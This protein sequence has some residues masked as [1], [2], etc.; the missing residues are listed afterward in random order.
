MHPSR[1]I[2]AALA[3]SILLAATTLGAAAQSPAP[4]PMAAAHVTGRYIFDGDQTVVATMTTDD[5]VTRYRGG[6]TWTGVTVEASDPR[7][8]PIRSCQVPDPQ[9][10]S[11]SAPLRQTPQT[12]PRALRMQWPMAFILLLPASRFRA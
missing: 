6:E 8:D 12:M 10:G 1:I 4:D 2:G 9:A 3:V 7:S 11:K 5:G